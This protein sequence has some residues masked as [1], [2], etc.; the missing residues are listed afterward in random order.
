MAFSVCIV[1]RHEVSEG[2]WGQILG[3]PPRAG[4]PL[5]SCR[6]HSVALQRALFRWGFDLAFRGLKGEG[7]KNKLITPV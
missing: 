1:N 4:L 7:I 3:R 2:T 5:S 6:C